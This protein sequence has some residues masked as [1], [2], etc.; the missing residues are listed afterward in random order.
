MKTS[1]SKTFPAQKTL[2]ILVLTTFLFT[3]ATASAM[4][5]SGVEGSAERSATAKE[6]V[7]PRAS[8]ALIN[9][10]LDRRDLHKFLLDEVRSRLPASSKKQAKLITRAI[11]EESKRNHLDPLLLMSMIQHESSFDPH[12]RGSHG[13]IG[14]VQLKPNTA[15][16]IASIKHLRYR[17]SKQLDNPAYNIKVGAAY[18]SYLR[19]R[20]NHEGSLY[21]T[22]Y[23]QGPTSLRTA[24]KDHGKPHE[25]M[26]KISQNYVAFYQA[27]SQRGL[28]TL[29][30]ASR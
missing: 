14:L 4:M 12:A 22:A 13:E 8:R 23:N 17:S 1:T 2:T 19:Q 27:W 15:R 24:L 7:G 30:V 16:W 6:I 28:D 20:F 9:S 18:L 3:H 5:S 26:Q 29:V 21:I 11:F 25:Y 10:T